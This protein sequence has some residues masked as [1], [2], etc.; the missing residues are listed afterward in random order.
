[1]ISFAVPVDVATPLALARVVFFVLLFAL[2]G[3]YF[4][5]RKDVPAEAA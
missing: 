1:M 2:A 3:V 5:R 4:W